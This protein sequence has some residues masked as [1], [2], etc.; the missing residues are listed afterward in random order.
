MSADLLK[1]F[2]QIYEENKNEK[3]KSKIRIG[4]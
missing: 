2:K 4:S 3:I 1:I